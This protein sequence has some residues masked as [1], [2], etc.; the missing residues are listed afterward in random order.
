[1]SF[2]SWNLSSYY[3][4]RGEVAIKLFNHFSPKLLNSYELVRLH[5][6]KYSTFNLAKVNLILTELSNTFDNKTKLMRQCIFDYINKII[7]DYIAK[8]TNKYLIT[9]INS[10]IDL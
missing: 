10:V 1:M 5:N 2:K 6:K 4:P 9:L 7:F 3:L 8:L